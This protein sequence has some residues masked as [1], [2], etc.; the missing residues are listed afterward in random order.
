MKASVFVLEGSISPEDAALDGFTA[1]ANN[2]LRL[3]TH[4]GGE[5]RY[6]ARA[7]NLSTISPDANILLRP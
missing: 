7:Y 4:T 1:R 6:Q 3:Y 2:E 5:G